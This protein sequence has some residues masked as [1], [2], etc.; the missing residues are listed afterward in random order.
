[1][2]VEWS[3]GEIVDRVEWSDREIESEEQR[4]KG[5]IERERGV[6]EIGDRNEIEYNEIEGVDG[7]V[8][9][10][11]VVVDGQNGVV[12]FIIGVEVRIVVVVDGGVVGEVEVD[13]HIINLEL[14]VLDQNRVDVVESVIV[15]REEISGIG[16]DGIEGVGV[17][18]EME[19]EDH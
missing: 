14:R 12:V 4:D 3:D 13:R 18:V 15:E 11:I 7:V 19:R 2:R 9:G 6:D 17:E 1:M 16:D 5:V 8:V 10:G